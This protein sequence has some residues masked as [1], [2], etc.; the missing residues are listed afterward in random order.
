MTASAPQFRFDLEWRIT[1]ATLL[2][3]P[4][5]ISLG[6]WQLERAGEKVRLAGAWEQRRQL[7]AADLDTLDGLPGDQ[8]AYRNVRLRGEFLAGTQFLLDYRI[9]QGRYGHEV[10]TPLREADSGRLVLVNRGWGPADPGRR[11][12]PDAPPPEG[13]VT[14][15]GHV[16]VPPGEPYLL[17][18][19]VEE[20][21]WPRRIQAV[22]VPALERALASAPGEPN[23]DLFPYTVRIDNGE[24]G[25]QAVDWQ[26]VNVSPA[27][28]R[29]YAVQWFAMALALALIFLFRNSNLGAVLAGLWRR[30]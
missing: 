30:K 1:L 22:Q 8:L 28:H 3:V 20:D 18:D 25:A 15:A 13:L 29:G 11:T 27:K 17:N 6:F 10:I 23:P 4:L 19:Q 5:F 14:V 21:G 12:L 26:V 7:P 2:L 9:L 16:Y 24:P